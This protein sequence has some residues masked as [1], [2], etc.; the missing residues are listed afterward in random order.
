[1]GKLLKPLGL[2]GV[3][4]FLV[5]NEVSSS[6]QAGKKVWVELKD[7][8]HSDIH[9]ESLIISGEKSWVKFFECDTRKDADQLSGL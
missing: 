2:K 5:F 4:R 8:Q 6:L 7:G 3:L 1:M 9:I